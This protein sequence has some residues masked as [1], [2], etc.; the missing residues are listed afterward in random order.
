[1]PM[2]CRSGRPN[3]DLILKQNGMAVSEKVSNGTGVAKAKCAKKRN[4]CGLGFIPLYCWGGA[5]AKP[6]GVVGVVVWRGR[7]SQ[8]PA[9]KPTTPPRRGSGAVGLKPDLP[10]LQPDFAT[11]YGE[12]RPPRCRQSWRGKAPPVSL[13]PA[14]NTLSLP[15][16]SRS[17]SEFC[18]VATSASFCPRPRP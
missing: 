1:M 17:C 12:S 4:R 18:A 9:P 3:R 14:S 2:L 6:D 13:P 7:L 16:Q 10:G 15:N 5:M 8:N 11:A